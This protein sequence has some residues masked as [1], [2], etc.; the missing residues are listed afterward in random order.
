MKASNYKN[1]P[2][3]PGVYLMKN[4]SGEIIY[5]GK[6]GNLK[7]RVSSY[8]MRPHDARISKMVSEIKNINFIETNDALEALVLEAKLIKEKRPPYNIRE[9]DDR[10]FLY[11][12]ITDEKFPRV[13]LVRGRSVASG[14]RFGPFTSSGSAREAMKI[15]RRIFPW[16]THPESRVGTFKKPCFDY[17]I[18]LCPGTCIGEVTR[19]D[20]M[21]NIRRLKLFLSG[22]KKR[23]MSSLEKEMLSESKKLNFEEASK[24][25]KK[26]FALTHVSDASLLGEPDQGNDSKTRIEGYDI[27]N[28]SGDSA[29]GSMVVFIGGVPD[30]DQYRKFKI[31]SLSSPNDVGMMHEMISR[32]L[33]NHWPLPELILVD[34]GV[35]QVNS[36]REALAENGIKIPVVGMIK[37]PDRKGTALVG[38]YVKNIDKKVLER[39]RDEAHRFAIGY[40]RAIRGKKLFE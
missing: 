29:V 2:D 11:I 4:K 10:S 36:A 19:S 25:K 12:E 20:Y 23:L 30:K 24:I 35:P 14:K 27:S 37:G 15:L 33:K 22:N 7:R 6:A 31:R 17:E 26:I 18:G 38:D 9:K 13:L 3:S 16:N 34:G 21:K 5:V 39:V 40:H 8:F 28:I 1:L 32:R